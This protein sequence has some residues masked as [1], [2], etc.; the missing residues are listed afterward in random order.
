MRKILVWAYMRKNI[1]DDL[2]IKILIERYPN[3][4]WYFIN[5]TEEQLEP[6]KNYKGIKIIT[7]LDALKKTFTFDAFIYIGGSIF[8]F[9]NTK[10]GS[11]RKKI[12][13]AIAMKVSSGKNYVLGSNFGPYKYDNSIGITKLYFKLCDDVCL[14][15][16]ASYELFKDIKSVRLAPDIVY[17]MN[18][19]NYKEKVERNSVGISLI[20]L[21]HRENLKIYQKLY[22]EKNIELI[23]NFIKNDKKVYLISFCEHEGDEEIIEEVIASID[24]D[25]SKIK[26]LYYKGN[27][28][29]FLNEYCIVEEIVA[30]RFHSFI[31]SQIFNQGVYPII[32]S[33]KLLDVLRDV[34]LDKYFTK[35]SEIEQMD[36]KQIL[37]VIE[38]NKL[39]NRKVFD[40]A[41]MQFKE[42]DKFLKKG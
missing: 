10:Y 17:S 25:R 29:E 26:K 21:K 16:Q 38:N 39:L 23:K 5:T 15:D 27:M 19:D 6:F 14:R 11:I 30:C 9:H 36:P 4:E 24:E 1:G 31:L 8:Q 13:L 3:M 12:L 35:I 2:F 18:I 34:K 42:L 7:Y 37:S 32:Y 22:I 28:D 41:E 40:E 20:D 33:E